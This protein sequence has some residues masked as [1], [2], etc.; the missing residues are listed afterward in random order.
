MRRVFAI[1]L[2]LLVAAVSCVAASDDFVN[3]G[4][5]EPRRVFSQGIE[6]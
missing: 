1:G 3:D 2:A 6:N 5:S 4:A